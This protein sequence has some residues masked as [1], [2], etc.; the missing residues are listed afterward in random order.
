MSRR[1]FKADV[2]SAHQKV[3]RQTCGV[4]SLQPGPD[5]GEILITYD[6]PSLARGF[7]IQAQAQEVSEYPD[8]NSFLVYVTDFDVPDVVTS[9]LDDVQG[10]LFGQ[11]VYDMVGIISSKLNAV[12]ESSSLGK[13]DNQKKRG[14]TDAEHEAEAA[15]DGA[16]EFNYEDDDWALEPPQRDMTA[17]DQTARRLSLFE[18][19]KIWRLKLDARIV[20]QA[21]Y[22]VGVLNN[23]LDSTDGILSVSVRVNKLN[24]S[25]EA[26]EAW[27]IE[28]VKYVVLL[29]RYGS[30]YVS[31]EDILD[32]RA[33]HCGVE[34]R[35]GLC[36]RYKPSTAEAR[37]AFVD[38]GHSYHEDVNKKPD[39]FRTM[40]VSASLNQF[41]NE[42]LVSLLKLRVQHKTTWDGANTIMLDRTGLGHASR[43]EMDFEFQMPQRA[44]SPNQEHHHLLSADHLV[45]DHNKPTGGLSFPLIAMQFAL[46]YFTKCTKYCLRC[47]RKLEE[48]FEALRPYVCSDPLCL[49]QYMS[50]GLGPDLEQEIISEPSVVD[51]LVSLCYS[52]LQLSRYST[53][54]VG[55]STELSVSPFYIREFP[56]GLQLRV[57]SFLNSDKA[58]GEQAQEELPA[59]GSRQ[60]MAA[61]LLGARAQLPAHSGNIVS[62][63]PSSILATQPMPLSYYLGSAARGGP[64]EQTVTP[65]LPKL[66]KSIRGSIKYPHVTSILVD[67]GSNMSRFAPRQR[68]CLR[69]VDPRKDYPR[70]S[71]LFPDH[72]AVI[73][74]VSPTTRMLEIQ[75]ID[76]IPKPPLSAASRLYGSTVPSTYAEYSPATTQS[77]DYTTLLPSAAC[78]TALVDIYP[79]NTD[80]DSLSDADKCAALRYLLDTLP[81]IS[82]LRN[83]LVTQ[84]RTN[85]KLRFFNQVS[86]SSYALL[87]WIVSSNR[88]YIHRVNDGLHADNDCR[89]ESEHIPNVNGWVQFR[90][91]QGSPDKEQCFRKALKEVSD[92]KDLGKYPTIFAW[93]GSKIVNWHSILRSG[94]DFKVI[95][96]GRAFGHGVYFSPHFDTSMTYAMG[97]GDQIWPNSELH[98]RCILSMNEIINAPAE[99]VSNTP[100]YVVNQHDWHQCR[101]LF[102]GSR[103]HHRLYDLYDEP[104]E[105]KR[106]QVNVS[107]PMIEQA[108]GLEI[109]G[110]GNQILQLPTASMPAHVL[111]AAVSSDQ[112]GLVISRAIRVLDEDSE[113]SDAEDLGLRYDMDV[114]EFEEISN[115]KRTRDSSTE[116]KITRKKSRASHLGTQK[117]PPSLM[118]TTS[119]QVDPT[120]TTF[121]PG[122]LDLSTLPRLEPPSWATASATQALSR[123]LKKLQK[124]QSTTPLQQQGWYMDF[125]KI[126]NLF[127]WT[128]ELH[129]FDLSLPFAQDMK[130]HNVQ[131]IV[132]E[133]RFGKDWPLSPPFVRIIRP[134]FLPFIHGGGGHVTGGGAMCMELLTNSGWS[135]AN[136]MESVIIQVRMALTNLEPRPARLQLG[137]DYGI[138]EAIEAYIRAATTHGWVVPPDLRATALGG[139]MPGRY[140]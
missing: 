99:F 101:Y 126:T 27:K 49:F 120:L 74:A 140:R 50:L 115:G 68:I 35:V 91:S 125:S 92:R 133:I 104:V 86:P 78:P 109:K 138:G 17:V 67:H 136:S 114:E 121:L 77:R 16:D 90:L 45:D 105:V 73:I 46:R 40:H 72:E 89:P 30:G 31:L 139:E 65:A 117:S 137:G 79:Y 52:S 82:D 96:A 122:I 33:A 54:T 85:A 111:T 36:S 9:T 29:L 55:S 5:D 57:P 88:S 28:D 8:G 53:T 60:P 108:P 12:L 51:L 81:K 61:M 87:R 129:S 24:L 84:S 7:T 6:H 25:E 110:P 32:R 112:Q 128:V 83:F 15:S 123:E 14:G 21:G 76:P 47:H 58:K 11:P 107:V 56:V 118:N 113:E 134:R 124:V 43:D 135:P 59:G 103:D 10:F 64:P 93:H 63:G 66:D 38:G 13:T 130:K 3:N 131:S 20:R 2:L 18:Q 42:T 39:A 116:A 94:L 22:R 75:V 41:M 95:S 80:L 26:L 34:F 100:H 70:S 97:S 102:V 4:T 37:E 98:A 69:Y 132:C 19:Q 48:G 106:K 119:Q 44:V 62:T 23:L 1:K 127:Q 71:L